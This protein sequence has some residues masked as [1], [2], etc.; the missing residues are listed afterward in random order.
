MTFSGA[1][2]ILEYIITLLYTSIWLVP[3]KGVVL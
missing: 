3:G 1:N 2:F